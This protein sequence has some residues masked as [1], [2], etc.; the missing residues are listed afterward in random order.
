MFNARRLFFSTSRRRDQGRAPLALRRAHN[1]FRADDL[2]LGQE[3]PL[4]LPASGESTSCARIGHPSTRAPLP[5]GPGAWIVLRFEIIVARR[6]REVLP[7]ALLP[8][9]P[10]GDARNRDELHTH[11]FAQPWWSRRPPGQCVW[12]DSGSV[13]ST[14]AGIASRYCL[15]SSRPIQ[16][17][18]LTTRAVLLPDVPDHREPPLLVRCSARAMPNSSLPPRS[19]CPSFPVDRQHA[20]PGPFHR[21]RLRDLFLL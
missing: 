6:D 8:R 13:L 1:A 10:P 3:M 4:L 16:R 17:S 12:L 2:R 7:A 5:A 21:S 14:V 15:A 19:S 9:S 11:S 18:G 20:A